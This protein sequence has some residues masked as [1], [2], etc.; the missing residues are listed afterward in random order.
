MSD[1]AEEGIARIQ[2]AA[3]KAQGT[4][5]K[6]LQEHQA[7]SIAYLDER[8]LTF[9]L[10]IALIGLMILWATATSTLVLYGSFAG[11]ILLVVLWGVAR[12]KRIERV[13]LERERQANSWQPDESN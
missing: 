8:I 6:H 9:I 7:R 5:G 12:V 13:R 11:I 10:A 1:N 3:A 4:Q 2:A